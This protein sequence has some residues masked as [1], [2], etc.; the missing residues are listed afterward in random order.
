MKTRGILE[1]AATNPNLKYTE[2]I[3]FSFVRNVLALKERGGM[4]WGLSGGWQRFD[5]GFCPTNADQIK[6]MEVCLSGSSE[7]GG[8][9]FKLFY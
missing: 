1:V 9:K 7:A 5:V 4:F 8:G 3:F 6:P 2:M